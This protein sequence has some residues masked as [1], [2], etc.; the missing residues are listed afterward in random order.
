M[1]KHSALTAALA[2]AL[3]GFGLVGT[4]SAQ[5]GSETLAC[6][7]EREVEQG[8]MS[9][10]V[11]NRLNNASE[12]IGEENF[13]EA[14]EIMEKLAESRLSDYEQA[15]VQQYL[16]FLAAQRERY[17]EA[18]RHFEEAIRLNTMPNNT[19]FDMI[20]QVAQL[21][22]AIE[23]YDQ[24][25]EQLDFWFCVS[26]EEAQKQAE[27]WV[28]KASLHIQKEEWREALNAI[29]Q[30]LA[31]ATDPKEEWYRVKLGSLLELEE[32]AEAAEVL[33]I[34][35]QMNPDRKEY[36]I[37]LSGTQMELDR[38]GEAMS[39]LRLAYRRGLL[40]KGT[41]FTQLAG[42]LQEMESPRQAAEVLEDGLEKGY[43]EATARN[44]EMTA[45]AWYQAR[46]MD[47]ALLAYEKASELS[48][49]GKLDFQRAMI[50]AGQEENWPG[51]SQAARAALRKG[52]LRPNEEGNAWLLIGM[53][54]F[55]QGNLDGAEQAFQSAMKYGT[56]RSAAQE[57]L[58]HIEQSRQ[59]L[60]SQ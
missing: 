57:W 35:I 23:E 15:T 33:K 56:V 30:A 53:A 20:L 55:S 42:L 49:R 28:L 52:D 19:H 58:N 18:I 50:M 3:T 47:N 13:A 37:Q 25:L 32:H 27:V 10:G 46:E 43:I 6:G 29:D 24:A 60:A 22:N 36:W 41:E 38:M 54:E 17:R 11:F 34:L 26:T 14:I 16:G 2:A 4:V 31:V 48:D 9:E 40:D 21:Y 1:N 12:A 39:A 8:L 59:R 44:W 51:V 45:G 5:V 7:E